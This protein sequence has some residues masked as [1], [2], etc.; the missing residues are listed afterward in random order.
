MS[1]IQVAV[2]R[3]TC[4]LTILRKYR[5]QRHVT[6]S[7]ELVCL[8]AASSSNADGSYMSSFSRELQAVGSS[9][10]KHTIVFAPRSSTQARRR[11]VSP[12]QGKHRLRPSTPPVT[13]VA[14]TSIV[15]DFAFK[16]VEAETGGLPLW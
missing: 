9:E 5:L 1:L 7:L 6:S 4:V 15:M 16:L 3:L 13:P 8:H 2:S 11:Q 12:L 14:V 10:S